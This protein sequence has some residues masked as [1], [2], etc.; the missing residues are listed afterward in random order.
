MR[1]QRSPF[2]SKQQLVQR[3]YRE[4]LDKNRSKK[5]NQNEKRDVPLFVGLVIFGFFL[6]AVF[7]QFL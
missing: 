6:L 2:E 7:E 1:V 5:V 4:T 3:I